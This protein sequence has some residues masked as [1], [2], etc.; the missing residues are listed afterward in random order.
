M[1][2]EAEAGITVVDVNVTLEDRTQG[3]GYFDVFGAY[4][5]GGSGASFNFQQA[6]NETG[7]GI[8]QLTLIGS[9]NIQFA[10]GLAGA[11]AYP[12]NLAYGA[13]LS[14]QTFGVAAGSRG[15]MAWG[16]GYSNS[17]FLNAGPSYIGFQFDLGGGTQWGWA[18][19]IMDGAPANTATFTRYAYGMVGEQIAVGEVPEPTSLAV[20]ALGALGLSTMRRRKTS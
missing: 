11:Y 18:E 17:Q 3:D 13:D 15:D 16:A 1:T 12:S 14:T 2:S 9:G 7:S 5:F 6:L 10:G 20:L 8:G 4:G 19:V